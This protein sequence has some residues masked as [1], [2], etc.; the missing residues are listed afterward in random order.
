[1]PR[2]TH[3]HGNMHRE[4]TLYAVPFRMCLVFTISISIVMR[5]A[6]SCV[7]CEASLRHSNWTDGAALAR[8]TRV[9]R[10]N[11][12][13]AVWLWTNINRGDA[14]HCSW[15]IAKIHFNILSFNHYANSGIPK[16][17]P[18]TYTYARTCAIEPLSHWPFLEDGSSISSSSSSNGASS[19]WNGIFHRYAEWMADVMQSLAPH[20]KND[21][22]RCMLAAACHTSI[23]T[24]APME[25]WST[26]V[27]L[28]NVH[29][30]ICICI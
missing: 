9:H 24:T 29:L 12:S 30:G 25:Q 26:R 20:P 3:T 14:W 2:H 19:I 15:R 6:L 10:N 22:Q 27:V 7:V 1:M 11:L 16:M 28:V 13:N 18:N 23:H 8:H 21:Q 17:N 4:Q 5:I